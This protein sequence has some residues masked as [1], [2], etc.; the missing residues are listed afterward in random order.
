MDYVSIDITQAMVDWLNG[1]ANDGIALVANSPLVATFD[2][3]ETTTTSHPPELDVVFAGGGGGGITGV[4][5][6]PNSGLT[7]GGTSGTLNLSL[8]T[9]CAKNQILAWSGS[10]WACSSAGTGTVTGVTAGTDLTGGGTS[11]NVTLNLD[12]TKV[13]QLAVANTFAATQSITGSLNV[14]NGLNITGDSFFGASDSGTALQV[15]Q[16]GASGTGAILGTSKSTAAGSYAILGTAIGTSGA[17]F[18]TEGSTKSPTGAGIVGVGGTESAIGN[19]FGSSA[20]VWG[21]AGNVSA[22][23]MVATADNAYGLLA[24]NNGLR[25]TIGAFNRSTA[26]GSSGTGFAFGVIGVTQSPNG[27]GLAGQASSVSGTFQDGH[28]VEAI[29]VSGDSGTAG[30]VGVWGTEDSGYAVFGESQ[31]P[32]VTGLFFN[33][34][35]SLS[36]ALE[37]GNV[38]NHCVIDTNGN[39]TCT[40]NMAGAV[41]SQG[42]RTVRLYAVQSPENWFE[43][44]GSGTLSNGSATVNLDP[45]FAQTVNTNVDYHVFITP[46]GESEGLYVVNKTAGGFEVRE[47]HGGH[48][49]VGF[50]YRIVGRRKGYENIRLEDITDKHAQLVAQNQKLLK[51]GDPAARGQRQEQLYPQPH[52]A[53]KGAGVARLTARHGGARA[54]KATLKQ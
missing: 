45:G 38:S 40:G 42:D 35:T 53:F 23:A 51:T 46:N 34:S 27:I 33:L 15:S 13:P 14:S 3:K 25:E 2:S 41:Q 30:G 4:L 16:G 12:T 49:N 50:D 37:A 7:G 19:Q 26:T 10:A 1:T 44:F 21:D 52:A 22:S 8:L 11:G 48:S 31:G 32:Y 6:G 24:Y 18:G 20:G 43:D 54:G 9:S 29:G 47:Q 5:T 36:Y 39:L 28:G 17:V